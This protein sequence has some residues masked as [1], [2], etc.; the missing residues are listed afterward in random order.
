M[1]QVSKVPPALLAH[2]FSD[3]AVIPILVVGNQQSLK[4]R[5]MAF[6]DHKQTLPLG[7]HKVIGKNHR[8]PLV[9]IVEHLRFHTVKAQIDG[10]VH[11]LAVLLDDCLK[12]L[13][14]NDSNRQ[15]RDIARSTNDH[16]HSTDT[17]TIGIESLVDQLGDVAKDVVARVVT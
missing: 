4:L 3:L 16:R 11:S 5:Y 1:D 15:R 12:I 17:T 9:A 8:R 6:G 14:D 2:E 7:N 13:F 10:D